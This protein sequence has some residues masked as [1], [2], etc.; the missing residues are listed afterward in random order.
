LSETSCTSFRQAR[1]A[2]TV[3]SIE[4]RSLETLRNRSPEEATAGSESWWVSSSNRCSIASSFLR[5][6]GDSMG[7][8]V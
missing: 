8:S 4:A 2:F 6:S 5:T 3:G 7:G 1:S